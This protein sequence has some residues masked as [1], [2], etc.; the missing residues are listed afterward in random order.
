MIID[1][2]EDQKSGLPSV[3]SLRNR[4]SGQT[5]FNCKETEISVPKLEQKNPQNSVN[6]KFKKEAFCVKDVSVKERK[7]S[8][9]R[10]ASLKRLM[11]KKQPSDED[12]D[13]GCF[14]GKFSTFLP[15][16]FM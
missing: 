12:L 13:D 16:S 9:K 15:R 7:A 11:V 10:D 5:P 2:V 4:F 14:T 6:P 8:E 3:T 1:F